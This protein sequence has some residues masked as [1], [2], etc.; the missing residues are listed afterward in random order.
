[1]NATRASR[2][3][4]PPSS[5]ALNT[6]PTALNGFYAINTPRQREHITQKPLDLMRELVK[7]APPGG[8]ILDQEGRPIATRTM[9]RSIDQYRSTKAN[10][11]RMSGVQYY[12]SEPPAPRGG[13]AITQLTTGTT[14]ARAGEQGR[15]VS[16]S[17]DKSAQA[18]R[19]P[20]VRGLPGRLTV[21]PG[22]DG[23]GDQPSGVQRQRGPLV[24][25]G[26]GRQSGH[27]AA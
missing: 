6:I 18:V 17:V 27:A 10:T 14:R 7:I 1:M 21:H 24:T 8:L 26:A 13:P 12:P 20:D 4:A 3:I 11:L 25:D 2:P 9:E 19:P 23:S 22:Q 15:G 5:R 16:G